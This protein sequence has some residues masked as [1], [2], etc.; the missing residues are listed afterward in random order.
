MISESQSLA[1]SRITTWSGHL[2][3]AVVFA[4][5]FF[6]GRYFFSGANLFVYSEP[7]S[8]FA[9]A[10]LLIG[11]RQY[12]WAVFL[13]GI[14]AQ[15]I[16]GEP[17][18]VALTTSAGDT[19]EA[20]CGV[21]LL[22]RNKDFCIR[23]QSL[24]AYLRLVLL[25]GALSAAVAA[26][27]VNTIL[28]TSGILMLADYRHAFLHW[29]LSDTLGII[30]FTPFFLATWRMQSDWRNKGR[31]AEFLVLT[32]LTI[33]AGEAI[34]IGRWHGIWLDQVAKG[35]WMFLILTWSALRL[36]I[37]E[38]VILL[39]LTAVYALIGVMQGGGVFLSGDIAANLADYWIYML[40]LSVSSMA[41]ATYFNQLR[42]VKAELRIAAT[43]FE[44]HE[45]ILIT[46]AN[47][48]ILRVNNAFTKVTGYL[49]KEAIG[50]NPSFLQSG[51]HDAA[52]YAAMWECIRKTGIWE[53]E[54]WNR[55]KNGA[56]YPEFLSITA[57]R[58]QD[59]KIANYIGSFNDISTS[60]AAEDEIRNLAFYD[61]LTHL[62][63]R[64][65]LLDRLRQA[66]I[67]S[68]RS[69]K[70]GALLFID[71][72]NF[73]TLNDTH[74]HDVGDMLL[75]QVA[76]RLTACVREVDSVARLGGDEFVV[77]LEDLGQED[78]EAAA[79]AE[80]IGEKIIA[81]LNVP[82]RLGSLDHYSTPSIGAAMFGNQEQG[83][84]ELLK[85]ADIA[86]YQAKHSGRNTLRFFDQDMQESINAR[87]RMEAALR[88]A[89]GG[90]Q[91]QLY[92]QPQVDSKQHLTGVEA[93]IRWQH[94]ERGQISTAQFISLAEETG[95]IFAI[96]AW[97]LETAC[98]QLKAW[99]QNVYTRELVLTI[100][101]SAK[102]FYQ[103]DFVS[104]VQSAVL[105]N[106][107]NPRRLMLELNENMML[108]NIGTLSATMNELKNIG[109]QLALGHFGSGYFSLQQ[110]RKLPVDQIKI[111]Q[112]FVMDISNNGDNNA[113]IGTI[114][115]VADRLNLD[116]IAEGVETAEQRQRLL[117]KECMHFQ[118]YLFGKPAPIE[119]IE[120]SLTAS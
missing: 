98:K 100:N 50:R 66:L 15:A 48:I 8:G 92:Y 36:G 12:A 7:A 43:T 72:D 107:I 3:V 24:E 47:G 104:R 119:E 102:Q 64:R 114:M 93:L 41:L 118:G 108:M 67:T 55:R 65:L 82:Y 19:L 27:A 96:D 53:G 25:G 54:I 105:R 84:D 29:W 91:L 18:L 1:S 70:K 112:S 81:S 113:I 61:S 11:G 111:D 74:G 32:S 39:T 109:V 97:V 103:R 80:V 99:Q 26:V 49:E 95:L 6:L 62:P 31:V 88:K 38:T 90:E 46:D 2:G 110:L 73:K 34:F 106:E 10:A 16:L 5:L 75:L 17:L 21:W 69:G 9:L 35:Y 83:V 85:Q 94:P 78:I 20:L 40:T 57:V 120:A 56:I 23:L 59:G 51:R 87:S 30:L 71:L 13:G 63:N 115:A 42:Q 37:C 14:S 101:I 33:L 22:N 86:M 60:K 4:A 77:M 79:K 45:G 68:A 89:I 117:N 52:F 116:V 44:S 28:L 76:E 58:G